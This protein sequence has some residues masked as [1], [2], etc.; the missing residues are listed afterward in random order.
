MGFPG[1]SESKE[2]ASNAVDLYSIQS[3]GWED[4]LEEGMGIHSSIFV[5]RIPMDRAVFW[6]TVQGVTKSPILNNEA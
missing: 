2:S 3:L 5:W 4:S 6:A 1:G